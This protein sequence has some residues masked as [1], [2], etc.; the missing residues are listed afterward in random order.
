MSFRRH[1]AGNF[2]KQIAKS[3]VHAPIFV[4]FVIKN[5]TGP[6]QPYRVISRRFHSISMHGLE[7]AWARAR[8]QVG[9]GTAHPCHEAHPPHAPLTNRGTLA[10]TG[11]DRGQGERDCIRAASGGCG[12]GGLYMR[13]SH[14]FDHQFTR[15]VHSDRVRSPSPPTSRPAWRRASGASPSGGYSRRAAE[16]PPTGRTL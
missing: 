3:L 8:L 6:G 16:A 9:S 11:R 14:F 12:L 15:L 1:P 10:V 2:V 13:N 5:R 4:W 7:G